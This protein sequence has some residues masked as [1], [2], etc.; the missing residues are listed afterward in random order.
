MALRVVDR[1]MQVHGAEGI[2]QDKPLA[3]YY[4]TLRT[5]RYA[6]VSGVFI[7]EIRVGHAY[8][9]RWR[10]TRRC[11]RDMAH[12]IIGPRRGAHQPDWQ[13]RNQESGARAA[14]EV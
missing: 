9:P 8:G 3:Y 2:S 6:D 12:G 10:A 7:P 5:L 11:T 1:A 4:A 13:A 14:R